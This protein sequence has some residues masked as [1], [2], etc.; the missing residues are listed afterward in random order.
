MREQ[1]IEGH[2]VFIKK[3]NNKNKDKTKIIIPLFSIQY[4]QYGSV[5]NGGVASMQL[6]I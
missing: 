6:V 1:Y 4:A 2:S 3:N 5:K